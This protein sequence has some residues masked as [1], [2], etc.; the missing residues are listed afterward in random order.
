MQRRFISSLISTCHSIIKN[1]D[2]PACINCV[3]FDK[4][5]SRDN[6]NMEEQIIRLSRCKK[7][8][9][10]NPISGGINYEYAYNCRNNKDK[11]SIDGVFFIKV[12]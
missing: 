11:C 10:K 2:I 3:H 7:F 4:Y 6:I 5:V 1:I 8:G 9:T 12:V